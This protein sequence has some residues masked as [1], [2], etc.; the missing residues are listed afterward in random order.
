VEF[1]VICP[2]SYFATFPLLV[3]GTDVGFRVKLNILNQTIK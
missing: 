3:Y 1:I 2:I